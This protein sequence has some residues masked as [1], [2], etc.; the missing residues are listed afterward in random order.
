MSRGVEQDPPAEESGPLALAFALQALGLAADSVAIRH[1]HGSNGAFSE[2]DLLRAARAFPVK[3]GLARIPLAR[4]G[5]VP[6]PALAP[7]RDGR[8]LVLG[9][10]TEAAAL[11]QDPL[12][13]TPRLMPL[14]EFARG[15]SGRLIMLSRRAPLA[16]AGRR[17]GL[18]WFVSAVG[19]YRRILSEVLVVSFFLQLFG[20]AVPLIFQVV[21]DKVLVHHGLSTLDLLMIGLGLV[22]FFEVLLGGLRTY[23]FAHTTSRIDVELGAR[24]FR[25]LF[26]LPMA[27]F[28]ARRVG[29]TV[30]RVR[31]LEVVRQF[32]TSSALTLLID[33][34][35]TGI[36]IAV[37]FLYSWQLTMIVIA[38]I[39]CYVILS[40][41]VTPLLRARIDERF[42]RGAETQ[43]MLVES[44]TGVETL[45][46]MA[47]EPVL[48]R[49]WEE[50]LAAYVRASFRT[51]TLGTA[52][53]QSAQLISKAVV[54]ATLFLGAREVIAGSLS[55]GEL[56]AF[57][58]LAAQVAQPV[59]RLAQLWQDFQQVRVAIERLGDILNNPVE[60]TRTRQ[61]DMPRI[62]GG[63]RFEHVRFRYRLDAPP[64]LDDV[65]FAVAP[66]QVIGI[67][68]RS[69][70]GKSTLAKLIQRF[71]V[72]ESGRVLIDGVD[73]SQADIA[74]LRRQIGS[75]LQDAILFNTTIRENIALTN[76]AMP[77][78]KI[79]QA[80][81]LAGAHEFILELPEGYDTEIGE[82][83]TSL[84]GGQRQR[85]AIAR[86]LITDPR[87]LIFD[88]ATS[89]LDYESE[90]VI[91][92]NLRRM[93]QGR[94]LIVIAHRLSTLHGADRII[95][96]ERGRII[97]DGTHD[98]LVRQ[99][100]DYARL[101]RMQSTAVR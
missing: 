42:L 76:P 53:S 96:I 91:Q 22:S 6:M 38:S 45:K 54:V 61:G 56:V 77:I 95:N 1:R 11:V 21:I 65:S 57:N 24:L 10:V 30:A 68:G 33:L 75:V 101:H 90:A 23:T 67:A 12:E 35:F 26:A 32:L 89:A 58:M 15:W 40:L 62:R 19:K 87:I 63:V 84:S 25:H 8:Y 81:E 37:M 41:I 48:Q 2:Q 16:E 51:I 34:L 44:I 27:Y 92:G 79:I 3:V 86:A 13:R 39:P 70:S 71:Y 83:G 55:V 72:P 60:T 74:W 5:R 4:L 78:E 64:V 14:E 94:T 47:A 20:L 97:E 36:F 88:E 85:I 66:G 59:L 69:G 17:F 31:Q 80:A 50:Q 29:D 52:G 98:E 7:M 82:R 49:R 28:Q 18:G 100:G 99:Q 43:A 93:A 46:A 9:R 73:I